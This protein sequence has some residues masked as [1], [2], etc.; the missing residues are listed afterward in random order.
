MAKEGLSSLA[1]R[2]Q[3]KLNST[4]VGIKVNTE[5]QAKKLILSGQ[6]SETMGVMFTRIS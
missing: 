6:I 3:T 1:R 5:V 4:N 2:T